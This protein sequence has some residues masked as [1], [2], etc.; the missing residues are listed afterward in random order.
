M[1][2]GIDL[3]GTKIEG[4]ALDEQG[5]QLWR[6]RVA[7]PRGDYSATLEAIATLVQRAEA[8]LTLTGTVGVGIPGVLSPQTGRVKNANSLCLNGQQ[9]DQDL[10][11]I[12]S[13]PVR[14]ANDANC[15]AVSEAIDGAGAGKGLV[16]G[17]ILGTGCGGGLAVDGKALTGGNGLSGEWGHN[18]LPWMSADEFPG[19]ECFCGRSGCIETFV[20]GTGFSRQYQALTSQQLSGS[21]IISRVRQQEP[22]ACEV[23]ERYLGQ[24]SRALAHVVNILDPDVIVLG[25]GLS[26]ID[27]LYSSLNARLSKQVL[28]GECA[29]LIRKNQHGC[30]SGVRGAAWLWGR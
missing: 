22:A 26:N 21:E 1:R 12:L 15:F 10:A 3:G 14:I 27:E 30:S 20:S 2:I 28:G 17:V 4:I 6:E 13:R 8:T 7:T 24:L 23:F 18:P 5:N 19:P 16:F 11:A 29:T 9:L 25:G